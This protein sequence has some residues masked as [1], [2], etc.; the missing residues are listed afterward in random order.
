VNV[1]GKKA[2]LAEVFGGAG[3]ANGLLAL[4]SVGA[5]R[6]TILAYH[7]VFD[8]PDEDTF[9]YDPELISAGP[10]AFAR[11][12]EFVR[13]HFTVLRFADVLEAMDRGRDLPAR[14]IV[15]T[16]DDG[17]RDNY[18]HAY[19][20][21]KALGIPGTIFL[22]TDYV[23]TDRVFWFDRVAALLFRAPAG[24]LSLEALGFEAVLSDVLS[25]RSAAEVLLE[26][27][28]QLPDRQ[29]LE[30]LDVLERKVSASAVPEA[31][32]AALT[33]DQVRE[34]ARG[35]IEFGSH[36]ASHP[37]LTMLDDA[38][39]QRE[40]EGSRRVIQR[41]TGQAVETVAYPVGK[42][43][44]YD[45]RVIRMARSCGYRLGVSYVVG[46]NRFDRLDDFGL[47]RLHVERYVTY[48]CFKAMLSLP[49]VF[50]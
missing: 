44:A 28:K 16:F 11:Q 33:W 3:L 14:S 5:R 17:H 45:D 12:M 10:A 15:I 26:L 18:T 2:M 40:L 39:L 1:R 37:I 29:R 42:K 7:R 4:S 32:S 36:A 8:V 25:R 9:P 22:S 21:L 35:G 43:F 49:E 34:M 6:L 38:T 13:R 20:V 46:V 31:G 23:G 24:V 50:A 41:E 48:R 47:K 30:H 27:L 19:P